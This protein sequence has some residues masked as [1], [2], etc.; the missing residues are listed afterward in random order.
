MTIETQIIGVP[1]MSAPNETRGL[2]LILIWLRRL[3]QSLD[4]YDWDS[5]PTV[6]T[7]RGEPLRSAFLKAMRTK[8]ECTPNNFADHIGVHSKK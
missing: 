2:P 6:D 3:N 1:D 7:Y 4:R 8:W 5:K